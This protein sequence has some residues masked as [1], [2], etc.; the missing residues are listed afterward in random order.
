MWEFSIA[1][2]IVFN[3]WKQKLLSHEDNFLN[4]MKNIYVDLATVTFDGEI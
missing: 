1:L 4:Q 3:N 2:V